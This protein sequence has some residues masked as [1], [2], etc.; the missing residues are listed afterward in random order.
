M[1]ALAHV[2]GG[3]AIVGVLA[4]TAAG[5]ASNPPP[6][7]FHADSAGLEA[8]RGRWAGDY[9]SEE[10]GRHGTIRFELSAVGDTARGEVVMIPMGR[11]VPLAPVASE[12][13]C[14]PEEES[15]LASPEPRDRPELLTIHFVR[16][17]GSRVQGTLDAY[18]DPGTGHRLVTTFSGRVARDSIRGT[19][20]TYDC[21]DGDRT[22]GRWRVTRHSSG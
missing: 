12:E 4:A 10:T 13:W 15:E 14:T 20:S 8:L 11:Q 21:E 5:C 7:S 16:A 6:T 19:Y 18:R 3:A 22:A 9:W 17:Y 1:K 2:L